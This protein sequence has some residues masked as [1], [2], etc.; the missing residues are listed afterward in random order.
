LRRE[1]EE[2][3]GEEEEGMQLRAARLVRKRETI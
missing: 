2:K 1:Q 3:K